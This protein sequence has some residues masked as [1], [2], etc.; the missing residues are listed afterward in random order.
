MLRQK[1]KKS[2]HLT[3]MCS[4]HKVQHHQGISTCGE[5]TS[6]RRFV[7]HRESTKYDSAGCKYMQL[8]AE[9]AGIA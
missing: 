3:A 2:D 5:A 4:I 8:A 9:T 7:C 6:S 1:P